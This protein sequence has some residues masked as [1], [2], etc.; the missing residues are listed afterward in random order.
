MNTSK[1]ATDTKLLKSFWNRYFEALII[2]F[3]SRNT[4]CLIQENVAR[5]SGLDS[6]FELCTY[7][8]GEMSK[9]LELWV[10]LVPII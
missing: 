3:I 9:V 2:S 10:K 4:Q 6:G 7:A 5:R 1:K 8:S